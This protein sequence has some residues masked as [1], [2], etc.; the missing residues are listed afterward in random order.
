MLKIDLRKLIMLPISLPLLVLACFL[1][2]IINL[3]T[4]TNFS[5]VEVEPWKKKE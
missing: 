2:L 1:F 5:V 3:L 4:G